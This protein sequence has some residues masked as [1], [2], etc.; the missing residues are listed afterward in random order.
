MNNIVKKLYIGH[1]YVCGKSIR[2]DDTYGTMEDSDTL[3][4]EACWN[5]YANRCD[6][7][8]EQMKKEKG[9]AAGCIF[10]NTPSENTCR[11][12][13]ASCGVRVP[14]ANGVFL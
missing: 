11:F 5:E 6:A 4:C 13:S 7:L 2:E 8:I 1:C 12:C 3:Y 14:E 9:Q 10:G